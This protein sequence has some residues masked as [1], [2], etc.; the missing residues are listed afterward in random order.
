MKTRPNWLQRLLEN[1]PSDHAVDSEWL[2]RP[3]P[4]V[5]ID[6]KPETCECQLCI[7]MRTDSIREVFGVLYGQEHIRER[8]VPTLV[9][10]NN[11]GSKSCQRVRDHNL[12]CGEAN[13]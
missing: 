9:V 11:C 12:P 8:P 5:G 3:K 13:K 6:G 10:C 2:R 7:E 1:L 4:G